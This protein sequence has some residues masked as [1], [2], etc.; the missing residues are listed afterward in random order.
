MREHIYDVTELAKSGFGHAFVMVVQLSQDPLGQI[1]LC[2]VWMDVM[3]RIN[4]QTWQLTGSYIN[5]IR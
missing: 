2:T 4:R 5:E 1:R 3:R